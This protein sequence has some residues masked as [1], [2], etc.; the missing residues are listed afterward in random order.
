[1]GWGVGAG[2]A[3]VWGA[4]GGGTGGCGGTIVITGVG[5]MRSGVTAGKEW[6]VCAAWRFCCGA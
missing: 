6:V 4:G 2:G 3:G 5:T 1:M